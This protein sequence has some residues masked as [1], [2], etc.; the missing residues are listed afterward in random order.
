MPI[1]QNLR[2]QGQYYDQETGLHYNRFRYYDSD[3]GKFVSQDPIGLDG[4]QNP[5]AY[6]PNPTNW[7]DQ[8]GLACLK[9]N[10]EARRWTDKSGRFVRLPTRD[11][12]DKALKLQGLKNPP[13]SFK[14]R[15]TDAGYN[16]EVR[17]HPANP[18]HGMDGSIYRVSRQKPGSGTEYMDIH[19]CWHHESTLREKF[20]DDRYN[21]NYNPAAASETH[22]PF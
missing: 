9:W 22:I 12:L 14:Q 16:Y 15:W 4:L 5:Y 19:G 20:K 6:A 13:A 7:I 10:K 18:A 21:P 3:C 2:F 17:A 1:E 8:F 11:F